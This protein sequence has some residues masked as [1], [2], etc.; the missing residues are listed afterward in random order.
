MQSWNSI[1]NMQGSRLE[2]DYETTCFAQS[3]TRD[4]M[5]GNC[6][7]AH[8]II[9]SDLLDKKVQVLDPLT[10][11]SADFVWTLSCSRRISEN[12]KA[13][14]THFKWHICCFQTDKHAEHTG[15]GL[16]SD[17][18]MK[19]RLRSPFIPN[20]S[21]CDIFAPDRGGLWARHRVHITLFTGCISTVGNW[22]EWK[23]A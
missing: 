14:K 5:L 22:I 17:S 19:I 12:R 7:K 16:D 6:P 23:W 15:T 11:I 20:F 4:K 18:S 2:C 21:L 9:T 8:Q 13:W 1:R 10:W 3:V